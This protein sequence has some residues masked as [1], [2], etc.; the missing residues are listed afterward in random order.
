MAE[1][2]LTVVDDELNKSGIVCPEVPGTS[3]TKDVFIAMVAQF[4][5]EMPEHFKVLRFEKVT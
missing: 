1:Y 5:G 3:N 4:I 2:R